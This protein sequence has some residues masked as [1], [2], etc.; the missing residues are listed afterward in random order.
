MY[1]GSIFSGNWWYLVTGVHS[2]SIR[3]LWGKKSDILTILLIVDVRK[4]KTCFF[5]YIVKRLWLFVVSS[6]ADFY[7]FTFVFVSAMIWFS[8]VLFSKR[9]FLCRCVHF[10]TAALACTCHDNYVLFFIFFAPLAVF[11]FKTQQTTA[12]I[13][14]SRY[15]SWR[16]SM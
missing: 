7:V 8:L 5:I 2:V 16:N 6:H 10:K 14:K 11:P 3:R 9:N 12:I 1:Y 4:S 13:L 15:N